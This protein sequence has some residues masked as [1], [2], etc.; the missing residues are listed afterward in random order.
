MSLLDDMLG[1]DDQPGG[2]RRKSPARRITM[3]LLVVAGGSFALNAILHLTGIGAPYGL[4]VATT[5]CVVVLR[6]IIVA[7][8]VQPVPKTMRDAPP[9]NPIPAVADGV[10]DQA[11]RWA[12]RLEWTKGDLKRFGHVVH[13]AMI[14]LVDERLRLHHGVT[15]AGQPDRAYALMGNDLWKF[16]HEP[17]SRSLNPKEMAALVAQMEAL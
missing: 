10:R 12:S 3:A 8:A 17:V 4:I 5:I 16:V 2:P 13:P 15:R 14:D 1:Y 11:N 6:G 7:L 9:A